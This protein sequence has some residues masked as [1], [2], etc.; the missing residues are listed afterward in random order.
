MTVKTRCWLAAAALI[1][2]TTWIAAARA[3]DPAALWHIVNDRCVPDELKDA[4]PSPCSMVDMSHGV[5]RGYAILK[6]TVGATQFLLIPTIRTSGIE[7]PSILDPDA[8]NY[9]DYAWRARY[10]VEA[11]A[12][13]P[14]PRDDVALAINSTAGRTQDQLHIHIDCLRSDVKAS[15]ASHKTEIGSVWGTFP[16]LLAGHRY[17]AIRVDGDDLGEINPFRLLADSDP[18]IA[19]DMGDQT[20]VLVGMNFAPDHPGFV[21]LNDRADATTG[22]RASGE[23]LQDHT[24]AVAGHAP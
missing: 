8:P 9:W 15:L 19:A 21:V 17:R 4:N 7:S 24:C 10:F 12:Q 5:D 6:D 20:L 18:K 1:A 16:E 23:E 14:L 2:G 11:R 13:Q 22:D 3:A